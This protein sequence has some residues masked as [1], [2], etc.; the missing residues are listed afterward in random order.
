METMRNKRDTVFE[1]IE[2]YRILLKPI[3]DGRSDKEFKRILCH[4][5][6]FQTGRRKTLSVQDREIYDFLLQKHL[7]AKTLYCYWICLEYP[8]HIKKQLRDKQIGV[9]EASSKAFAYDRMISTKNGKEIMDDIRSVIR[10]LEWRGLNV[11]HTA[12]Q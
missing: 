10:R 12:K 1:K 3:I 8:E 4:C 6:Y 11:T 9:Q 2:K 7:N 5:L